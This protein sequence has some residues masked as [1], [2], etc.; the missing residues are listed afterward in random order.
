MRTQSRHRQSWLRTQEETR[1]LGKLYFVIN[2]LCDPRYNQD[3]ILD[4]GEGSW[5]ALEYL[6]TE[7]ISFFH[8]LETFERVVSR[9][10]AARAIAIRGD[11]ILRAKQH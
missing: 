11:V 8:V 9:E 3:A 2:P 6:S 10:N 7:F 4:L 5:L 1:K